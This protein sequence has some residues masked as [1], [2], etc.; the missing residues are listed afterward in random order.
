MSRIVSSNKLKFDEMAGLEEFAALLEAID[1]EKLVGHRRILSHHT[2]MACQPRKQAGPVSSLKDCGIDTK[3]GSAGHWRLELKMPSSFAHG[4]GLDVEY[5]GQEHT[6]FKDC[7]TEAARLVL[8]FL[9]VNRPSGVHL[10]ANTLRSR[11]RVIALAGFVH[12]KLAGV[13][14]SDLSDLPHDAPPRDR[15]LA[16]GSKLAVGSP[17]RVTPDAKAKLQE[18]LASLPKGKTYNPTQCQPWMWQT[19]AA[20]VPKG[21]LKTCLQGL[22]HLLEVVEGQGQW[23]FRTLGAGVA[24][25]PPPP[26][27]P[28]PAGHWQPPPPPPP[29]PPPGAAP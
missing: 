7:Q 5:I 22:P 18:F 12:A 15:P 13:E 2:T 6:N 28:L 16:T 29:P 1:D 17:E 26:P 25:P 11:E 14:G 27:P 24:P 19:F 23:Q 9:L 21:Q 4:D 8:A 20:L 10:H 3:L